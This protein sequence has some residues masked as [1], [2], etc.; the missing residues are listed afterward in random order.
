MAEGILKVEGGLLR[1]DVEVQEN[2]IK[3]IKITGDFFFF[4]EEKIEELEEV[5]KGAEAS[6]EK[7]AEII[8]KFYKENEIEAS[9]SPKDIAAAIMRAL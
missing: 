7:I 9:I 5:L 2:K 4:P 1:I 6:E 8:E 3:D